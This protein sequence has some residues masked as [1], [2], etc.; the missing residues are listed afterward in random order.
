M[1]NI[2]TAK[3]WNYFLL[4]LNLFV[5]EYHW[6]L[7]MSIKMSNKI[8][9]D[10]LTCCF[11]DD[12]YMRLNKT[13]PFKEALFMCVL[14]NC[15]NSILAHNF[16]SILNDDRQFYQEKKKWPILMWPRLNCPCQGWLVFKQ[17]PAP[18]NSFTSNNHT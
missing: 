10:V 7:Y 13:E 8:S 11:I 15:I 4:I 12:D 5:V 16:K 18:L 6:S 2:L 17:W 3:I 9:N 14:Q 1:Y